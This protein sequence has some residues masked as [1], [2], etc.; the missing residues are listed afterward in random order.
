M[1]PEN[2]SYAKALKTNANPNDNLSQIEKNE[3]NKFFNSDYN[4]K[5]PKRKD[6]LLISDCMAKIILVKIHIM[7]V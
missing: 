3:I 6:T 2:R 4:K 5:Y 7:N 1:T